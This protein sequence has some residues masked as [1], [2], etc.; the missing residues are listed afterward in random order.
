VANGNGTNGGRL[1]LWLVGLVFP[2]IAGAGAGAYQTLRS[3]TER[4][5]V[6]ESQLRDTDQRLERIERKIDRLIDR[7]ASRN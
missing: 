7:N 5:A 4:I 6:L 2:L 3:N 1:I